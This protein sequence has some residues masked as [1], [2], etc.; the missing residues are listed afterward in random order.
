[1]THIEVLGPG[2]QKC[3]VLYEHA[4]QA[5]KELGLE[6]EIKKVTDIE[7]HHGLRRDVHSGAGRQR[8]AQAGGP[9]ALSRA[10]QGIPVMNP[11]RGVRHSF[12]GDRLLWGFVILAI[13]SVLAGIGYS[14]ARAAPEPLPLRV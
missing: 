5:A 6:F 14:A 3:K 10:A 9:R 11:F 12:Q 1:M 2:C 8:R 13:A 7:R 4:E